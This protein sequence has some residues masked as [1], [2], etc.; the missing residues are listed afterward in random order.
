MRCMMKRSLGSDDPFRIALSVL[1][2]VGSTRTVKHFMIK[3]DRTTNGYYISPRKTFN[4]LKDL[5]DYYKRSVVAH[6]AL[7]F[8]MFI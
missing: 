7:Q 3:Y 8:A 2:V 5:I 4:N 1:N 6:C